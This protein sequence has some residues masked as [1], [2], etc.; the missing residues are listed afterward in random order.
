MISIMLLSYST[1][2]WYPPFHSTNWR[3]FLIPS[4]FF[5]W[6]CHHCT[7]LKFRL[8]NID[9]SLVI[10]LKQRMIGFI[11]WLWK[12]KFLLQQFL[13]IPKNS[14]KIRIWVNWKD[15]YILSIFNSVYTIDYTDLWQ[16]AIKIL[17]GLSFDVKWFF[18]F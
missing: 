8:W 3:F 17:E 9:K 4:N 5:K 18:S 14:L 6:K 16:S 11:I 2:S 10:G 13:I 7:T 12:N 1:W 15:M